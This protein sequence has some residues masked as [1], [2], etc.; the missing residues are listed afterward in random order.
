MWTMRHGG[1]RARLGTQVSTMTPEL[2][3]FFGAPQ[4]A[5]LLVQRIEPGSA[6]E[7]AK[8]QVG[9]VLV[10]VD[11]QSIA[12]VSDVRDAL[13]DRS[14]GDAVDVVVVRKKKRKTLKATLTAEAGPTA[15]VVPPMPDLEL[16]L[17]PEARRFL[18]PEQQAEIERELE[19]A[20]EELR[21][22]QRQLEALEIPHAEAPGHAPRAPEAPRPPEAPAPPAAPKAKRGKGHRGR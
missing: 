9:D 15:M 2:R 22:A 7:A 20:R 19:R 1:S 12:A 3:S 18:S 5:G 11:G 16:Q 10:E 8:V 21:E 14:K 6:A 17:P 13:S 4:D